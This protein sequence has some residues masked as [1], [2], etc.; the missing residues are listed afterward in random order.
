MRPKIKLCGLTRMEDV[1][2]CIHYGADIV[3]VVV[4]Y[5]KPV[6]WNVSVDTAKELLS[7]VYKPTESCIV[8]GGSKENIKQIAL[9]IR[10]DYV[11][12]HYRETLD[13]TAYLVRALNKYGIRIIKTLFPD[14]ADLE[15]NA[16]AFCHAGVY[17]LLLDPRTPERIVES[18]PAD[19]ALFRLVQNAVHCPVILAG[20]II[21]DNVVQMINS[22][23][24]QIIDV[25]T[26]IENAAG[27]KDEKKV[28]ALF[29][30]INESHFNVNN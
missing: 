11:Q 10:P 1:Q 16:K 24:A 18:G 9:A 25:M 22:S 26:G 17:A 28:D 13:D 7:A 14:V 5:P 15:K 4:E 3:G 20:G 19:L 23:R 2:M 27:N 29:R 30:A 6:P 21:P 8:V 12:L